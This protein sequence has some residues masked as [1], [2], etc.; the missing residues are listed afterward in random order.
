LGAALIPILLLVLA[1][2]TPSGP[3]EDPIRSKSFH[4]SHVNPDL[5]N[6]VSR[7]ITEITSSA[8]TVLIQNDS[9][10]LIFTDNSFQIDVYDVYDDDDYE[11]WFLDD[12]FDRVF[13]DDDAVYEGWFFVPSGVTS[14]VLL[15]TPIAPRESLEINI[16]LQNHLHLMEHGLYRII[17]YVFL[18]EWQD[19]PNADGF[20]D[21]AVEFDW[22]TGQ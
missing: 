13:F 6:R 3:A 11:A 22:P 7:S 17:K 15:E 16:D 14:Y 20:H 4:P 18:P 8:I 10:L 19:M 1:A 12:D 9:D 5:E 2:C 21:V